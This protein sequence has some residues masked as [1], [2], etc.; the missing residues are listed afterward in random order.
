[1]MQN[2]YIPGKGD[3]VWVSLDPTAG[4]EQKGRRPALVISTKFFAAMTGLIFACPITNSIDDFPT[5]IRLDD[6]VATTGIIL[7]EHARSL[8]YRAR[9]VEFREQAPSDLAELAQA[10]ITAFFEEE[11]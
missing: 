6:R 4:H 3:I 5:H 10:Y 1:M 8:D 9:Q 7:C 11:M 2:G